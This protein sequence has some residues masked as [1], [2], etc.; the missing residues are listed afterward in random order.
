VPTAETQRLVAE[1]EV[2]DRQ[3]TSGMARAERSVTKLE[4]RF[5][6]IGRS[7][8]RGARTA[9]RNIERG[10]AVGV[11]AGA[12][13]LAFAVHEAAKQE[14]A[15]TGIAKTVDGNI[16]G[17]VDELKK[18]ATQI[19]SSFEELAGIA[20]LG[21]AMG[22]A[23]DDLAAFTKQVA[24]L[25]ATTD[26]NVEDAATALGQFQNVIGLTGA[27]FDNFAASLVDLGNKG[28]STEAQILEIAKRSG[29][30]AK[31][32]GIAKEEMLGW[33]SAAANL[34]LGE[35]LAG[36]ALQKLFVEG[37]KFIAR[38]GKE[39]KTFAKVSGMT[40]KEFQRAWEKD[41]GGALEQFI[42]GL[43][44]LSE[45]ERILTIERLFKRGSGITRLLVG[46]SGETDNLTESLDT[47]RTAWIEGTAAQ[48][49][50]EKRFRTTES[51][52]KRLG[53]T[54]SLA[55]ATIGS[56]LLPVI[57]DLSQEGIDWLTE[58]KTQAALK[59]FSKDLAKGA[60][61]AVTWLKSLDWGSIA[62]SLQTAAGFAKGLVDAFMGFPDWVKAAVLTGWGL[63]K[64]TGG[65]LTDILGEGLKIGFDQFLGKGSSP[66]NPLWV[67]TVGAPLGGGPGGPMGGAGGKLG[68]LKTFGKFLVAGA[69]TGITFEVV[70]GVRQGLS[71]RSTEQGRTAHDNLRQMLKNGASL[72][73][74]G[75]S[76]RAIDDGITNIQSNPLLTLVQG[77]ALDEL[78]T[79]R[80][81]LAAAIEERARPIIKEQ[82]PRNAAMNQGS[83]ESRERQRAPV[84]GD[85]KDT[86]VVTAVQGVQASINAAEGR[87]ARD[88]SAQRSELARIKGAISTLSTTLKP[89]PEK[90]QATKNAIENA[91][92]IASREAS[93]TQS[94]IDAARTGASR[95]ASAQQGEL[96]RIKN[97]AS[98]FAAAQAGRDL[99]QTGAV[100]TGTGN[101]TTATRGV[102][103][104]IVA[105]LL[106][107]FAGMMATMWAARPVIN[108]NTVVNSYS[109]SQRGGTT[110]GSRGGTGGTPGGTIGGL[111][112][113]IR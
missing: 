82:A 80:T 39:L 47:S 66:A 57:V 12:G 32:F 22:V 53:N 31:L 78:K 91:R 74:M 37:R 110:T 111:P 26:V 77:E 21:G 71:D 49:E 93:A 103:P 29:G 50:A 113:G 58:P 36:T 88:D 62:S 94:A 1:L 79:M 96:D 46:L 86:R 44:E 23:K 7:A 67:A 100:R 4:K 18:M 106:A 90:Q 55:A 112:S 13:A 52:M 69:L 41:A 92:S 85:P 101:I 75:T 14:S 10:I 43:G 73:D 42:L 61:E 68:M 34:G 6:R 9:G 45:G 3:F 95:D 48:E 99:T 108:S 54:V 33:A 16:E 60:R 64:L 19:P 8:Q 72:E 105:T 76:L 24:I 84:T 40:A 104:P 102:A 20:E 109:T 83:I 27:E 63:N 2:K 97:N 17:V 81:E 87:G 89:G 11:T 59:A 65:A 5:D 38:G 51:M 30:A 25:G 15:I 56:E 98:T 28:A 70:E 35:E 107:G